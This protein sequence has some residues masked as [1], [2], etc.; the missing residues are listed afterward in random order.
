MISSIVR[1]QLLAEKKKRKKEEEE[2]EEKKKNYSIQIVNKKLD[3]Q[4]E[5]PRIRKFQE[6]LAG[7]QHVLPTIE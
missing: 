4:R 2:E 6:R 5:H 3:R 1:Q 7:E